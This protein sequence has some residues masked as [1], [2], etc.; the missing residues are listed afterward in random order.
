MNGLRGAA[1]MERLATENTDPSKVY[2]KYV[3]DTV[4][5]NMKVDDVRAMIVRLRDIYVAEQLRVIKEGDLPRMHPMQM[6]QSLRSLHAD[7]DTFAREH[8]RIFDT[9]LSEHTTMKDLIMLED[10]LKFRKAIED[11][12]LT[13]EL[14]RALVNEML[15]KHNTLPANTDREAMCDQRLERK[16]Q[17]GSFL[18]FNA[19]D[20]P[21]L[22]EIADKMKVPDP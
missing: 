12:Q 18:G 13:E 9:V 16:A 14:S 11:G 2:Y 1:E 6:K 15:I 19:S 7:I 5:H 22:R 21:Y 8:P 20:I 17:E 4:E 10:M 3:H